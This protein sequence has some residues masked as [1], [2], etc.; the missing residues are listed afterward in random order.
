[1]VFYGQSEEN[2]GNSLQQFQ[3]LTEAWDM[4]GSFFR[5]EVM[6]NSFDSNYF[7]FEIITNSSTKEKESSTHIAIRCARI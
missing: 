1:V 7:D 5:Y 6:T 2:I 4:L 3:L